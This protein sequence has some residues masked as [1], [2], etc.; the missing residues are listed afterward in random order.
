MTK[1]LSLNLWPQKTWTIAEISKDFSGCAT[2]GEVIAS[3]EAMAKQENLVVCEVRANGL[4]LTEEQEAQYKGTSVGELSS[5]EIK[6]QKIDA[7]LDESLGGCLDYLAKLSDSMEVASGLFRTEDL[8]TAHKYYKTCVEGA[9]LF[10]EMITHYKIVYKNAHRNLQ[11]GIFD[12]KTHE[13]RLLDVLGQ[14]LDAYKL[15]NYILVADL[16]EY[17]LINV[18]TLWREELIKLERQPNRDSRGPV[19]EIQT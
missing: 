4:R 11:T 2:L 17:D 1:N 12:W 7:L 16:L 3:A 14:I 8:V 19:P 15:K 9:E 5:F 6:V 18:L 13:D 10:I